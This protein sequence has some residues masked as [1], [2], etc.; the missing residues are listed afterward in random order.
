MGI[1]DGKQRNPVKDNRAATRQTS[2]FAGYSAGNK[3]AFQIAPRR[4]TP[5]RGQLLLDAYCGCRTGLAFAFAIPIVFAPSS[6]L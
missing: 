6:D 3:K 1:S 5:G 2:G 4:F